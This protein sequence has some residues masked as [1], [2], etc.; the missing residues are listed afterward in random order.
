MMNKKFIFE[1]ENITYI[2]NTEYYCDNED[3]WVWCGLSKRDFK[4]PFT[5]IYVC[6]KLKLKKFYRKDLLNVDY[7][8]KVLAREFLD[9]YLLNKKS[10]EKEYENIK[11]KNN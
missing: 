4:I 5:K 2:V 10:I 7:D 1:V 9:K 6:T 8:F 11:M 3:S